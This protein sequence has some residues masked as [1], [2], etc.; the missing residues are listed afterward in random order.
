MERARIPLEDS[1]LQEITRRAAD[2]EENL[3]WAQYLLLLQ[4]ASDILGQ[5]PNSV[6]ACD[7]FD[8]VEQ[9]GNGFARMV[10]FLQQSFRGGIEEAWY[11]LPPGKAQS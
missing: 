11:Y 9:T 3:E 4:L 5:A 1:I 6:E 8:V 10:G 7:H 2:S